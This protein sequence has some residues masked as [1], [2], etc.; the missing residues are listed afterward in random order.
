M[1]VLR[2][3]KT[4]NDIIKELEKKKNKWKKKQSDKKDE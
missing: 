4:V 1:I 2:K 3:K